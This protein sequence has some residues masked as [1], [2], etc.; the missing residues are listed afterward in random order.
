[1]ISHS[2]K[3]KQ[4]TCGPAVGWGKYT[5]EECGGV[6]KDIEHPERINRNENISVDYGD[7]D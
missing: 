5:C 6:L 7:D 4:C 1:M 2:S 3:K